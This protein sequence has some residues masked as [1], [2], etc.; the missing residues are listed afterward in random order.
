[1]NILIVYINVQF[2]TIKEKKGYGVSIDDTKSVYAVTQKQNNS[3]FVDVLHLKI[4]VKHSTQSK[5]NHI[6]ASL[7]QHLAFV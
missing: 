3:A 6:A 2:L 7:R 1:M 4:T 5:K